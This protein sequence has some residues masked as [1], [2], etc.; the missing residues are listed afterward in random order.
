MRMLQI[1]A[2]VFG[3]MLTAAMLAAAIAISRGVEW[4]PPA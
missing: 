4:P 3:A 2:W 1:A